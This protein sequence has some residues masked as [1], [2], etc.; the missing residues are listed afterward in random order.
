MSLN[1]KLEL[2]IP[3]GKIASLKAGEIVGIVARDTVETYTGKYQT[4]AV[5]CRV[6]LG[7]D[8]AFIEKDWY[9]TQIIHRLTSVAYCAF[10]SPSAATAIQRR[11]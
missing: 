1:E 3:A 11:R 6:N 5:N 8:P 2:L 10:Q 7:M 4:S 9:V